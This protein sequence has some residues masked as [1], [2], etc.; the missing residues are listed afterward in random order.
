MTSKILDLRGFLC[1]IPVHETRK[2]MLREDFG[3]EIEIICD[4]PETLHDIPALCD[5]IGASIVA[6]DEED[7]E[8]LRFIRRSTQQEG[9]GRRSS[10]SKS[11]ICTWKVINLW[12]TIQ[13]INFIT[14]L[15]HPNEKNHFSEK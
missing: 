7:G 5:R 1:P 14:S 2:A 3:V 9:E 12:S 8:H 15:T 10:K 4:D 11:V 13:M 6:I